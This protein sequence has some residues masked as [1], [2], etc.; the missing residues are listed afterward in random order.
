MREQSI[1]IEALEKDDPTE[2]AAY[3]DQACGADASL[4]H[5]L[6]RL[7]ERHAQDDDFLEA[8]VAVDLCGEAEAGREG[9]GTVIGAYKLV[10]Q[11]GEG[12]FGLVFLADQQQPVRRTVAIKVLKPGM[13]SRQVIARFEA[14]RQALA[15]M[16]HPNIA[17][18]FDAGQ[19]P[20]GRPHFVM[21]LVR[22]VPITEF[23]DR[24]HLT[25]RQRLE[26]FLSVCAAVQ[27]AHQKG[28][29]HRDIKPTNVLVAMYDDKPVVKVIDFGIAKA[30]GQE[31][32]DKTLHTGFAQM[33]GT[34]L[35]MSPEQAQMSGLDIDTR[36]DIYSLGVL[37]YELLTGTT[38]F[39]GDRLRQA[40]Y[41]EMRRIIREEEPPRPS[42]RLSTLG[43]AADTVSMRR[44]GDPRRLSRLFRGELDWIVMRALEKDR[45]RRYES[46]GAFADDVRRY[47]WDEPVLACPPSRWYLFRKFARRHRAV[48]TMAAIVTAAIAMAG[49]S[50]GWAVRD[51]AERQAAAERQDADRK[52]KVER[53][54][55]ERKA[56]I[57]REERARQEQLRFEQAARDKA[58]DEEVGRAFDEAVTLVNDRSW[59]A[60]S[61]PLARAE[62][63]LADA[64]RNVVP[65]RITELK[66]DLDM[67][68]RLER[69]LETANG[70]KLGSFSPAEAVVVNSGF[71]EAFRHFGIDVPALPVAAAAQRIR[72]RKVHRDLAWGLDYW[73]SK[74]KFAD[75]AEDAVRRFYD[76]K[77]VKALKLDGVPAKRP[78]YDWKHLLEVAK[79]VDNDPWRNQLRDAVILGDGATLKK[80]GA[81]APIRQQH[82]GTLYILGGAL[83]DANE[84]PAA[85][86]FLLQAQ[87]AYPQD[88]LL[89]ETLAWLYH[90]GLGGGAQSDQ[91][92]R[93]Y[94][95]ALAIRPRSVHLR[96]NLG[97]VLSLK[98]ATKEAV[99][100]YTAALA[101][102]PDYLQALNG[103]ATVLM[104][105]G[106]SK[107]AIADLTRITVINPGAGSW[108][109]R[110]QAYE[111]VQ[112]WNSALADYSRAIALESDFWLARR[113][114]GKLYAMLGQ[115]DKAADD[116]ERAVAIKP[117]I[118]GD[119][120]DWACFRAAA[121][122][123]AGYRKAREGMLKKFA[124]TKDAGLAQQLAI[125][126]LAVP[127]PAE[128]EKRAGQ[129]AE[130]SLAQMPIS[131][132]RMLTRGLAL[133][134][135]GEFEAAAKQARA[136][137]RGLPENPYD[138]TISVGDEPLLCWLVLALVDARLGQTEQA[139]R[140]L[141]KADARIG[142]LEKQDKERGF[143][144]GEPHVRAICLV[145][146]REA[147]GLLKAKETK[148]KP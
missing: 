94:A 138:G 5:R 48:L 32:T 12:G 115:W 120:V 129:L 17:R 60:A 49:G 11:I 42:T 40:G 65:E 39:D 58:L 44:G 18:V 43:Q 23:C 53:D 103:R 4:R 106:R 125:S 56:K 122:D 72:A 127:G 24:N 144:R 61:A 74:R 6:D 62:K 93:F 57:E 54:D 116:L 97:H 68:F 96:A 8:P 142:L 28:V 52:A 118:G 25:T 90:Q 33:I 66:R 128:D 89:N 139:R 10:E 78:L 143:I 137:L 27:H 79:V 35:Y 29:I 21:E 34:P 95:A 105:L 146:R 71:T 22:G 130:F 104:S 101:L 124:Q 134:R 145:L 36:T 81:T 45:N 77:T 109:A 31:L 30:I 111:S 140:W 86:A 148:A 63:L 110:G 50:I 55:A 47:L 15:L 87:S 133:Y 141:D 69:I 16:D 20:S 41:D 64:G 7:L 91:A 51:R 67:L 108:H 14:E 123:A 59:P 85:L 37:L 112:Q 2:R 38:P 46:A 26:L 70:Y 73:A 126:C 136:P 3:L 135:S 98:G 75:G 131:H 13:D 82:P 80:L 100:E 147:Q 83:I 9:P 99:A 107:E 19:A 76:A 119:W 117:D 84:R 1:F 121:G 132:L 114:R 102:D 92:I 113:A 88:L